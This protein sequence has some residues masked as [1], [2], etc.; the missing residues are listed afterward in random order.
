MRSRIENNGG[1]F[2]K[3]LRFT[4]DCNVRRTKTHSDFC[5]P[6][7]AL[8]SSCGA[9]IQPTVFPSRVSLTGPSS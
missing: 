4:E 6:G 3:R 1:Q 9:H 5:L 7:I 8:Y 2:W